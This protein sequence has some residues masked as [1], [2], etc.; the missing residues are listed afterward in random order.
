MSD[1]TSEPTPSLDD[2]RLPPVPYNKP[3]QYD[4]CLVLEVLPSGRVRYLPWYRE[5]L[6]Y[7]SLR[8]WMPAIGSLQCQ[9]KGVTKPWAGK[10]VFVVSSAGDRT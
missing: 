2:V 3:Q 1:Q 5:A 7:L 4:G 10:K 9:C 8:F 6:R